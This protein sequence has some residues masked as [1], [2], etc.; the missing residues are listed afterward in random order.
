M[1]EPIAIG[2][3]AVL[4]KSHVGETPTP[5]ATEFYFGVDLEVIVVSEGYQHPGE[6]RYYELRTAPGQSRG[7]LGPYFRRAEDLRELA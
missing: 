3:H 7:D 5:P 6:P 4:P 1:K 2:T